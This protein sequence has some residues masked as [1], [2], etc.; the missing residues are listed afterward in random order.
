MKLNVAPS[1]LHI[2][3]ITNATFF[4]LRKVLIWSLYVWNLSLALL[5]FYPSQAFQIWH[6]PALNMNYLTSFYIVKMK[7]QRGMQVKI[8]NKRVKT[9]DYYVIVYATF[10]SCMVAVF[11]NTTSIHIAKS[12]QAVSFDIPSLTLID[13]H[14]QQQSNELPRSD[15][16]S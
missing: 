13:L 3:N 5:P 9:I 2:L 7:M 11:N 8:S 4:F 14:N 6:N 15:Y 16:M 10:I 12:Q 1:C